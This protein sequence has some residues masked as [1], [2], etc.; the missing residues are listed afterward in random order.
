MCTLNLSAGV[1]RRRKGIPGVELQSG[2]FGGITK[3][4][5][6][7]FLLDPPTAFSASFLAI[8]DRGRRLA[9]SLGAAPAL[10]WRPRWRKR[11]L[12]V[13]SHVFLSRDHDHMFEAICCRSSQECAMHSQP[14]LRSRSA[15]RLSPV[16]RR[17]LNARWCT[18]H[19][20]QWPFPSWKSDPLPRSCYWPRHQHR[21][22]QF[23][24]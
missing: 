2:R 11:P 14:R 17:S 3:R 5:S 9:S 16:Y 15:A 23:R 4:S 22:R 18:S 1:N 20:T 21:R 13:A 12:S 7:H 10:L 6:S 24:R 8:D 19:P